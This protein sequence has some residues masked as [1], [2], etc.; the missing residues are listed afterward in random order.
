MY[1]NKRF[2]S[3]PYT[4]PGWISYCESKIRHFVN[5]NAN[6]NY[7]YLASKPLKPLHFHPVKFEF[8]STHTISYFI[9]FNV[10]RQVMSDVTVLDLQGTIAGFRTFLKND[11]K[12]TFVSGLDFS[13]DYYSWNELYKNV[14]F[15]KLFEPYGGR[16]E[17]K[18]LRALVETAPKK[19]KSVDKV[20]MSMELTNTSES[21]DDVVD[22]VDV[23]V[24]VATSEDNKKMEQG[25]NHPAHSFES[26]KRPREESTYGSEVTHVSPLEKKQRPE[27]ETILP[28][29][30]DH[31]KPFMDIH[32]VTWNLLGGK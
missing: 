7:R 10:D 3:Y 4:L 8:K 28:D 24:E 18:K 14:D 16:K 26:K 23:E 25:D 1:L 6:P 15:R 17:A 2:I 32:A 13:V 12:G 31:V 19:D 20:G 22:K 9:G 27:L 21:R 11:F 29:F 30:K 5:K